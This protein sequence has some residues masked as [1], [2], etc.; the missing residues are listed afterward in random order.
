[1]RS[2]EQHSSFP[3]WSE[4]LHK[5]VTEPGVI[6]QAFSRFH[7]YSLGNQLLALQQCQ[8]R[9]IEPGPIATFPRWKELGRHVRKG[10]KALTLCMPIT[11]KAT[12]ATEPPAEVD[13]APAKDEEFI[14]TR[15]AYKAHWFV[16]A[17][18]DG[19]EYKP[20][21]VPGW[22]EER[23]L[24]ALDIRRTAFGMPDGN[25]QG[26]AMKR[27]V[28]INP[29]AELQQST[30]FHEVAHIVLGHTAEG[31][32]NS[33]S[34]DRTPR[35]IRELEAECVALLC[36]ESLDVP[37]AA[38]SRGYIQSWFKGHEVPERS[39]QRIFHAAD[40]ILKAGRTTNPIAGEATPC[41]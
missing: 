40:T 31:S 19:A 15:F 33:D 32:V 11:V 38:E 12:K 36:C 22:D 1:M 34:S 5:A 18:T 4:L 21:P 37:G 2:Y 39:A 28:A 25:L 27:E 16:L 41:A 10:E 17:Q 35:N 8:M 6:S 23:A 9:H 3:R 30:L 7:N 14:L 20:E 13:N 26:Y 29:L 24:A